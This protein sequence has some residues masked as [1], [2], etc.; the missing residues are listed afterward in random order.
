MA[1]EK[2]RRPKF[3]RIAEFLGLAAG[4]IHHP[5]LGRGGDC[6]LPTRPRSIIERRY[7]T[8]GQ[9][10]LDAALD[11]LMVH[12]HG[13]SHRKKG[14]VLAVGYQHFRPLDS[15]RRFRARARN[16]TQRGQILLTNRQFDRLPP[17]S[18]DLSPCSR[19][20]QR[21]YKPCQQK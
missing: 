12:P 16:R 1:G 4:K 19:I 15:A 11:G 6:R 3:V 17:S 2:S 18:H 13:L 10:P 8:V 5:C 7:R 14:R 9:C 20:K 21:G